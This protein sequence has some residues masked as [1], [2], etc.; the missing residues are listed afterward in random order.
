MNNKQT[1]IVRKIKFSN[2]ITIISSL[3]FLHYDV[4]FIKTSILLIVR[5]KKTRVCL[6]RLFVFFLIDTYSLSV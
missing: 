1:V 5:D 4:I 3:F 2:T 6:L